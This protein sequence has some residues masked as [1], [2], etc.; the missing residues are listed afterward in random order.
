MGRKPAVVEDLLSNNPGVVMVQSSP[1]PFQPSP[2]PKRMKKAKAKATVTQIDSKDIMPISK[3]VE[4]EKSAPST[5]KHPAEAI[6]YAHSYAVKTEIM[7]KEL[8]RKT[9]EAA[10]LLSSLNKVEAN[11]QAL[12]DQAKDA[13]AA[14]SLAEKK[15]KTA[16]DEAKA[17]RADL[18]IAKAKVTAIEAKLQEALAS[19]EAEVKVADEKAFEEG[20]A[21][22][23]DQYK[24]QVNLACNRGYYLS[25]TAILNKLVVPMDSDLQDI[26]Q[27][28]VP[29][30]L[31]PKDSGD[32]ANEDGAEDGEVDE[33]EEEAA[34]NPKSPPL[35]EQIDLT[36][37]E[38]DDM[39]S[40]GVFPNPTT[41]ET[42]V[43]CAKR[44]LD[45]TLQ[46]IDAEIAP[47]K[48][49]T[50]TSEVDKSQISPS[51]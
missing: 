19:K 46:E 15:A 42:E 39:V 26:N 14:Q 6:Q 16:N 13:K 33:V 10:K 7:R 22:V 40:K 5:D 12:M 4:A 47:E 43:Q 30:P 3:L 2:K 44:S 49:T 18:E 37:D 32:D 50:P 20:Q 1:S 23:R 41:S 48:N 36:Q 34:T 11:N 24:Q 38:K 31:E 51:T 28:Q 9:K 29:F 21:A 27:L 17:A 35:N 45:Q 8:A 25:W